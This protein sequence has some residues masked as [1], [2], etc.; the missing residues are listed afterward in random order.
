MACL[1]SHTV[2]ELNPRWMLYT[3][4]STE[5]QLAESVDPFG[6]S[7]TANTSVEALL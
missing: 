4:E 3:T 6:D 7:Y 1:T 5:A 2:L